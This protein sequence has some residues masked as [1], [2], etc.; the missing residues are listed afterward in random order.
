M[1][2]MRS[3]ALL[4]AGLSGL[5]GAAT[6]CA[7][8]AQAHLTK[9]EHAAEVTFLEG[10]ANRT[11]VGAAVAA[12]L[13]QG[14]QIL[15]GDH[16]ATEAKSRVEL[17]LDDK[18]ILR[19]G[20]NA[21]LALT[22]ANFAGGGEKRKLTVKL[23]FGN[24]WAKVASAVSG[25]QHFAVETENAVAGVRG[26]TFRVDAHA[27]KSV[28]V[29]VYAGAVAVARPQD[30]TPANPEGTLR[31]EVPGPA[32]VTRAAWE[33]LVGAQM[34]IVISKKGE[35]GEPTPFTDADEANDPFAKW[36]QEQDAK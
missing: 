19:L 11:P 27:D 29:R 30:E 6:I 21:E 33:K 28:L 13:K 17:R 10:K 25:D 7:L 31:K 12:H 5:L 24:L 22:E 4:G 36:N 1:T 32:E 15:Q 14:D 35:P 16:I 20:P 23:F 2:T 34:Q 9:P 26:T 8:A 18:S 3:R